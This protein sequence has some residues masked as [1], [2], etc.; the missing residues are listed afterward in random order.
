MLNASHSVLAAT[1]LQVTAFKGA[2]MMRIH[3][4]IKLGVI[5]LVLSLTAWL[6]ITR[7]SSHA[8]LYPLSAPI[9]TSE[10]SSSRKSLEIASAGRYYIALVCLAVGPLEKKGDNDV[11]KQYERIPCDMAITLLREGNVV[12]KRRVGMLERGGIWN[13][14]IRYDLVDLDVDKSGQ[15]ELV[16]ENQRDLSLLDAT[17][18]RLEI[19]LNPSSLESRLT[20]RAFS[21]YFCSSFGVLG[22]ILI[23]FGAVLTKSNKKPEVIS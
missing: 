8:T 23:G 6:Y 20:I 11:E 17:E 21:P 3:I 10:S 22:L 15:Y 9:S 7:W 2:R 4:L 18:P 13:G 16:I 5:I 14:K 1:K 12:F 19:Y